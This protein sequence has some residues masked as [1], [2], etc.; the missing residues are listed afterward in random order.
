MGKGC[1][2]RKKA[3]EHLQDYVTD[4]QYTIVKN[5]YGYKV[6]TVTVTFAEDVDAAALAAADLHSWI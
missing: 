4:V 2:R 6:G 3:E 1:C 5:Y